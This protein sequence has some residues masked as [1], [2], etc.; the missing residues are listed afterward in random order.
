MRNSWTTPVL[1]LSWDNACRGSGSYK[2]W[3]DFQLRELQTRNAKEAV[4]ILDYRKIAAHLKRSLSRWEKEWLIF[5]PEPFLY[6][7]LHCYWYVLLMTSRNKQRILLYAGAPVL[8]STHVR[9]FFVHKE[10]AT[11][12]N[13]CKVLFWFLYTVQWLFLLKWKISVCIYV[14]LTLFMKQLEC[15]FGDCFL[16][17]QREINS[18]RNPYQGIRI[19]SYFFK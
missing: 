13:I 11:L 5:I 16:F 15:H 19:K 8:K 2:G 14:I 10:T 7:N 6:L 4:L 18:M 17:S 9:D 3:S 1:L 12:T